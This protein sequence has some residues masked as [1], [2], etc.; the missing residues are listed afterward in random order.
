MPLLYLVPQATVAT[1]AAVDPADLGGE[2]ISLAG[3][4]L[5]VTPHGDW[6]TVRGADATRQSI[7]RE[8]PATPNSFV[9]RSEWGVGLNALLFKSTTSSTRD[10]AITN[11]KRRLAANPRVKKTR[12]VS[13]TMPS[14]GL[15]MTI[16]VDAVGGGALDLIDQVFNQ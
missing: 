16:R 5:G 11:A 1:V 4:T 9:H 14:R 8:F 3:G 2:D 12:E 6:I 15:A 10:Q 13:A 7:V